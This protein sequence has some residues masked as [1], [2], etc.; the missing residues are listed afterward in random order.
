MAR[1]RVGTEEP[2]EVI[3]AV[4]VVEGRAPARTAAE[5]GVVAG[6]QRLPVVGRHPPVLAR[7]AECVRRD[8]HRTIEPEVPLVRPDVRAV[9]VDHE[10][11][12]AE[13]RHTVGGGRG[14]RRLPLR[15]S[16]P[17]QV[18]IEEDVA[19]EVLRGRC[20]RVGIALPQ[21]LGPLRPRAAALLFMQGAEER[22][23]DEPPRLLLDVGTQDRRACRTGAPLV[24]DEAREGGAQRVML[25]AP[26]RGVRHVRGAARLGQRRPIGFVERRLAAVGDEL[27]HHRDVDVDRVDGHGAHRRVRRLVPGRHFV[28]RQELENVLSGA[29]QPA[30]ERLDVTNVADAPAA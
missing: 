1:P 30:A 20:Q 24:F 16:D 22:V 17:L 21:R 10:R 14:A 12:I 25:D 29:G 8:A 7:R 15:A 19:R 23:V 3:D 27:R 6:G 2:H 28:Q 9:Q 11:Q 26:H 18:L 5:P 13:Q 4:A